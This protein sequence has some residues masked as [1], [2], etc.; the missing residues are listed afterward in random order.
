MRKLKFTMIE[1]LT[2]VGII[3]FLAAIGVGVYG[4]ASR[5][6][7]DAKTRSAIKQL[8]IALTAYKA[9]YGYY[10]QNMTISGSPS[11]VFYLDGSYTSAD[12]DAAYD[13]GPT[14]N[15]NN[16]IDREAFKNK[17][18]KRVFTDSTYKYRD[19]VIDAWDRQIEYRCPGIKN[20]TSFDLKSSGPNANASNTEDD[21]SN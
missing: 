15:F 5:S 8:E 13:P 21:I 7:M 12:P 20:R 16:F 6:M 9:K 3:A 1:I 14:P 2:V 18:T 11:Y 4:Y 10:V 17:H 19:V